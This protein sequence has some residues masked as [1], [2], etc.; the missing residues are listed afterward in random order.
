MW[1]EFLIH[2]LLGILGAL[3]K[4]PSKA[5]ALKAILIDVRDSINGL[6]PGA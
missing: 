3:V 4:N 1:E 6:Y 5:N 2:A